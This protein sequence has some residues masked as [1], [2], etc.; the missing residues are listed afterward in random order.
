MTNPSG[1]RL[2]IIE[3]ILSALDRI[4]DV[5]AAVAGS[6][7]REDARTALVERLGVSDVQANHILDMTVARQTAGARADLLAEAERLRRP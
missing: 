2:H 5:N 1:E 7:T 6:P 4:G 3:G